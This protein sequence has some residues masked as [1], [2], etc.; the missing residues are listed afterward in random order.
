VRREIS[1]LPGNYH[2]SVDQLG[3]EIDR[4]VVTGLPAVLLF[5]LPE[6]KDEVGSE[7][8]SPT[9][10]VQ[11]AIAEIKRL[12]PELC[13]ITDVCLCEYTS[14][15]HCGQVDAAERSSTTPRSGC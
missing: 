1:S 10:P 6:H 14:H 5:G 2:L 4:V 11:R 8:F 7:A 9:A 15:G 12:A 3:P 13:V